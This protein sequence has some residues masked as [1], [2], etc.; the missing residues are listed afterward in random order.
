MF[1]TDL[2]LRKIGTRKWRLLGDLIYET[3][4]GVLIIVP[5]GFE[6]DLASIPRMAFVLTPPVGDYDYAAVVHDYLYTQQTTTKAFADNTFKEAMEACGVGWYTRN[7]MY[8]AVKLFGKGIWAQHTQDKD[9]AI[10]S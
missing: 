4:A 7:K 1:K 6:T 9:N 10:P 8:L 3:K 5:A 2:D